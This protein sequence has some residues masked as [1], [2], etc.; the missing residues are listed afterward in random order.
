MTEDTCPKCREAGGAHTAFCPD[1]DKSTPEGY[2]PIAKNVAMVRESA[3]GISGPQQGQRPMP[4]YSN[5]LPEAL[6]DSQLLYG[7]YREV[8]NIRGWIIF[9]F[10]LQVA[11]AVIIAIM[12]VTAGD[13]QSEF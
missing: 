1:R 7:I 10:S 12:M 11:A 5:S 2:Q 4:D 3:Q 13:S 8:R 6:T 9:L